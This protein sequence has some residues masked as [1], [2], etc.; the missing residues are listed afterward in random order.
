[1]GGLPQETRI[2]LGEESH[3]HAAAENERGRPKRIVDA[4]KKSWAAFQAKKV[5]GRA[6]KVKT[7]GA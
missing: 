7:A 1:L 3:S 5:Q 6:P 4:A 2:Q